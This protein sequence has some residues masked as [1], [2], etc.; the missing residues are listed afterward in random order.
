MQSRSLQGQLGSKA[1]DGKAMTGVSEIMKCL[2]LAP[3]RG[4]ALHIDANVSESRKPSQSIHSDR[5][6]DKFVERVSVRPVDS[7][8]ISARHS[9]KLKTST[10]IRRQRYTRRI[11]MYL[12]CSN[13][14]GSVHACDVF[15]FCR[16][17]GSVPRELYCG[18]VIVQRRQAHL[19]HGEKGLYEAKMM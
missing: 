8:I 14:C 3:H 7:S 6:N 1:L 16:F 11:L 18:V 9:S 13:R 12:H 10:L 4:Q 5:G 17:F 19:I 15:Q 2:G